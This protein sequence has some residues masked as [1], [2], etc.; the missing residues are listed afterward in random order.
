MPV[1][2]SRDQLVRFGRVLFE[3]GLTASIYDVMNAYK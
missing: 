3:Y 2:P 1:S